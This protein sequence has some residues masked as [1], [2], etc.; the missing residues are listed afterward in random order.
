MSSLFPGL[1]DVQPG[2]PV[3]VPRDTHRV[4]FTQALSDRQ[5]RAL[6]KWFEGHPNA[7]LRVYGNYKASIADLEFLRYYPAVTDFSIDTM[8]HDYPDLSGLRHLPD[9]LRKLTLG[10]P[11]GELGSETLRR[12]HALEVLG[13]GQHKRLPGAIAACTSV[14]ELVIVG[15]VRDLEP[16]R[17]LTGVEDLTLRS[18]SVPDLEPLVGMSRLRSLD[19]KLGGIR[20]LSLVD[21][22]QHLTYLELW[23]VK[24]LSDLAFLARVPSLEELHLES[25]RNVTRLP[26]FATLPRLRRVLLQNLKGLTDLS[27]VAD[28]PNLELL[29]L[30]EASHLQ[31]GAVEP[32]VGHPSL[33]AA[34][35]GFGSLRKNEQAR[36]LLNVPEPVS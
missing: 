15:P 13:I 24:G 21:R 12:M 7:A 14:T 29:L 5:H 19:I 22:F 3:R 8:Y 34:T 33:R 9:G 25:L 28:A 2:L 16:L 32:F 23:M 17:A 11:T 35:L 36:A 6:G 31:P 4:Q 10:V 18:V 30:V 27:P 1:Y 26:S 20:D